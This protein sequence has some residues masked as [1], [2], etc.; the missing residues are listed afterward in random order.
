VKSCEN[1]Q[2]PS[3]CQTGNFVQYSIRHDGPYEVRNHEGLMYDAPLFTG[4]IQQ[5]KALLA[6]RYLT[7]PVSGT[8]RSLVSSFVSEQL[9]GRPLDGQYVLRIYDA[10]GLDWD[11]VE[12]VQLILN[13]RFWTRLD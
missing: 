1:S 9:W 2:F 11:A 8:D 3:A 10:D 13:Y 5:G 4:R 12:D 6:E 7:N